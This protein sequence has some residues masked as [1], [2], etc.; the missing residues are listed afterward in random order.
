MFFFFPIPNQFRWSEQIKTKKKTFSL[1]LGLLCGVRSTRSSLGRV[2]QR[3]SSSIG[4]YRPSVVRNEC[5][6]H[7]DCTRCVRRSKLYVVQPLTAQRLLHEY[8]GH[9]YHHDSVHSV[10]TGHHVR[11]RVHY[12]GPQWTCSIAHIAGQ[13]HYVSENRTWVLIN[14]LLYAPFNKPNGY[15][16]APLIEFELITPTYRIECVYQRL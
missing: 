12:S 4:S 8:H 15:Y 7:E 9:R 6:S 13:R 3:R 14:L 5:V 10:S 1:P 11:D 16:S 2:R